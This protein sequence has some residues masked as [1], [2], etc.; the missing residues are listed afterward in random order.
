[1]GPLYIILKKNMEKV[2]HLIGEAQEIISLK[3]TL[4]E[5]IAQPH[6]Y[7]CYG[8]LGNANRSHDVAANSRA[9]VTTATPPS[10]VIG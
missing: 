8:I 5:T 2:E 6:Q 9:A 10:A 4:Q 1:M 7:S 3:R